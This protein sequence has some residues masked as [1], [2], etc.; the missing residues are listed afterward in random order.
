MAL[1]G[2]HHSAQKSTSTGL[3]A[4]STSF[5]Q[6]WSVKTSMF[7][8]MSPIVSFPI[9][10][11]WPSPAGRAST[12]SAAE[13]SHE[14]SFAIARRCSAAQAL[15]FFQAARAWSRAQ[16]RPVPSALSNRKPVPVSL[17][18]V[19]RLHGVRE[20][21]RRADDRDRP[22][23]QRVHLGEAARL[24]ARGHE[25]QVG[26]RHHLVGERLVVGEAHGEAVGVP[27][28]QVAQPLLDARAPPSP[29]RPSAAGGG[30]SPTSAPATMSKPFCHTRREVT[31]TRGRS[32][33]SGR[34]KARSRSALHA[35]LSPRG[36]GRVGPR[37]VPVRPRVP[38]V[39]VDAVQDAHH[40]GRPRAHDPVEA[41]AVL[42]PLDLARVGR[43]DGVHQLRED[44]PALQVADRAVVLE[45]EG[46]AQV[47]RAGRAGRRCPCRTGPGRPRCGS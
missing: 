19:V 25:E 35:A 45:R 47:P 4:P 39:V 18:R 10:R 24:A 8:A 27:L 28:L 3:S 44:R 13:R 40:V 16:T 20:P 30:G 22:V 42:R 1:H 38:L 21:A 17:R 32:G 37:D 5:A 43:G 46:G 26:A 31:P 15:R 7:A 29:A 6:F 23:A 41:E 12:Y 2:A 34:P 9:P 14:K 11:T 36:P 33:N